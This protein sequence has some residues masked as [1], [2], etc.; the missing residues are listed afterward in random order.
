MPDPAIKISGLIYNDG[1]S[2][3]AAAGALN[4]SS[5]ERLEKGCVQIN[6]GV[7]IAT[8]NYEPSIHAIHPGVL[9]WM[10][11]EERFTGYCIVRSDWDI[12]FYIDLVYSDHSPLEPLAFGLV[13]LIDLGGGIYEAQLEPGSYNVDYVEFL[14]AR[15]N[16]IDPE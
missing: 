9:V 1:V 3:S 7:P 16:E 2:A 10:N 6:F 8:T 11:P 4:I 14:E 15:L 12:D 5:V 13:T